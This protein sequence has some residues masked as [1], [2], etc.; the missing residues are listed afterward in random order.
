M[1]G[2]RHDRHAATV[3]LARV[4]L[5]A[6]AVIT[7][8]SSAVRAATEP[9]AAPVTQVG[10]YRLQSNAWVNLHQ[11]L[12]YE[13]RFEQAPPERLAGEDLAAWKTCGGPSRVFVGS[14][15]PIV[16]EGLV[17]RNDALAATSGKTTLPDSVP[18]AAADPLEAAMPLYR[19]ARWEADDRANRF[20]IAVAEPLLASAGE[21]LA[22]AHAKAYGVPFPTR[23]L[24]DVTAFA[25]EF[26]AYT[27][28]Q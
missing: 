24:V 4:A 17:R 26:G 8:P 15:N 25:W 22:A 9:G 19:A 10:R 11:R 16:D 1:P 23:I 18:K 20:W 7:G 5:L 12:L 2:S 3:D 21:E 28:G 14:R 13:A 6:F 27:V